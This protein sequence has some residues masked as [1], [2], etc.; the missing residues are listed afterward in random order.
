MLRPGSIASLFASRTLFKNGTQQLLKTRRPNA[1]TLSMTAISASILKGNPRSALVILVMSTLS[2]MITELTAKKTRNYVR[3]MMNL[4]V[5]SV[6]RV[7][8]DGSE[9]KV[10]LEEITEGDYIAVF[11]GEK[12]PADG[13]V[14]KGMASIDQSAITGEYFPVEVGSKQRVFAGTII[15]AGNLMI[16]VEEVGDQTAVSRI[17]QMIEE[18]QEKKAPIQSYADQLSEQLVPVSFLLAVMTYV[19]TKSWSRVLNMLVIDYV[20]G[21]KLSTATAISAS[22]GKAASNGA[23][24]KGGE[25]LEK[26]SKIDT[27]ILDKTGTITK[28]KPI[29]RSIIP[30]DGFTELEVLKH[31]ASAEEHSTHPIAEAIVAYA[32]ERKITLP[33]H[34]HER[35]KQVVGQGVKAWV[36]NKE[37]LVGNK[38]FLT[39]EKVASNGLSLMDKIDKSNNSV[40]VAIEHQLAGVVVIED[41][42]REGMKRTINQLRRNGIDEIV[43]ITGDKQNVAEDVYRELQLDAYHSEILPH[44]KAEFVKHYKSAGNTVMMVGDGIND[45]PALAY[46]DVGVTMGGKRTDIAVEASDLVINSDDPIMLADVIQ[47]SKRAMDT[48]QQNFTITI[49]VNSAAIL[50][51]ALGLITP[52]IGAA[53][54]NAAT[55]G[56]VLNSTRLLLDKERTK[57]RQ[58]SASSTIYLVDSA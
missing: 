8:P 35:I 5:S 24:I 33:V 4:D 19:L 28:G 42:I 15:K 56:V 10:S 36:D 16:E 46:A 13:Y 14:M 30:Y 21:I 17:V 50:L 9:Q 40:Y 44:Q 3:D 38:A 29:V 45:A 27:A 6:L 48:I 1:D 25:Y 51:G 53:I 54:H 32:S 31:A 55:I 26:L 39:N 18:A 47:Q 2:E 49:A 37:V 43:M 20:C 11:E 22:I 23:L 41:S 12:I 7:N 52:T 58:P 34:D 57:W